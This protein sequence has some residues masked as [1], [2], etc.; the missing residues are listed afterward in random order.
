MAGLASLAAL[1][2]RWHLS[3]V[4]D[5][6]DGTRATLEGVSVFSRSGPRLIQEESGVLKFGDQ[7]LEARQRYIWEAAGPHLNVYFSDM[8]PFHAVPLGEP[9][10]RTVHLCDP[11]RYEVVYDFQAWPR[12]TSTWKVEGPRKDYEMTS[13][14]APFESGA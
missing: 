5:H 11:D 3:R 13:R 8:R 2:G 12:W 1:A 9:C 6:A 7:N 14:Y 4:I 10:P